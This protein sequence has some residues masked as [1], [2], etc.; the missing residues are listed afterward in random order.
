MANSYKS[1]CIE[2]NRGSSSTEA[3]VVRNLMAGSSYVTSDLKPFFEPRSVGVIGVSRS[4]DKAGSV[5][6]RNLIELKFE[7]K[8]YPINPKADRIL[9][10]KAYPSIDLVPDE[11]DT[12]IIATPASIIVDVMESCARKGVR[13]AI[14]ISS[15]F[16]EEGN[17]KLEKEMVKIAKKAGIRVIGPNTTGVLNTAN[18][19]ITT[20]VPVENIRRGNVAIVAQTGMFLGGMLSSF[21]SSQHFGLSKVVGLGNKCDV[22]DWEVLEYLARDPETE[23]IGMYIEGVK[24]GRR[25]LEVAQRVS[26]EKPVLIFKS[27]VTEAGS[28]VALSHTGSLAGK[29]EV[30]DAACKQAAIIRVRSFDELTDFI[31]AFAFQPLPRG[32]RVAVVSLTGAGCV[33]AADA[34]V[35]NGLEVAR[36]SRKTVKKLREVTPSWHRVLNPVD[37]WPAAET[38]GISVACNTAINALIEDSGVDGVIVVLVVV[39]GM[40]LPFDIDILKEGRRLDKPLFFSIIG[41]KDCVERMTRVLEGRRFPVYPDVRRAVRALA[42]MNRY[43]DYLQRPHDLPPKSL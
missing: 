1:L 21:L 24:D 34:C 14:V 27:G 12:A 31:K 22:D 8:V 41:D 18:N 32:N 6:F 5:I 37:L 26:S 3:R 28:R 10:F 11:V 42:A 4:P 36:L 2:M 35:E 23:V 15:G 20:F 40:T 43:N 13:A 38:S 25:F 33:V 7:G 29:D 17:E 19:F 16:S 9:G 39:K 30:F